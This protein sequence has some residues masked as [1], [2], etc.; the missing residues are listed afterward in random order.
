M[1]SYSPA[2]NRPVYL[3][4]DLSP[5]CRDVLVRLQKDET[6]FQKPTVRPDQAN[7]TADKLFLRELLEQIKQTGFDTEKHAGWLA[8]CR[9]RVDRYPA[10]LSHHHETKKDRVNPYHFVDR[11]LGQL[12]AKDV[13][14][15]GNGT[16][17]VV[18][19]QAGILRKGQRLIANTGDA[20]MGYD[21]P[22][23]IGAAFGHLGERVCC[24]P[25]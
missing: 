25:K 6:E 16:A 18:V 13:V 20:S 14:V 5:I 10:I 3:D 4:Q 7:H 12:Q 19:I 21:L 1:K 9:W 2:E 24:F 22:A 11:L 15:C 23:A 17:N 8:W